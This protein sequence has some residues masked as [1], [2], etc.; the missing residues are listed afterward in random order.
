MSVS[1]PSRGKVSISRPREA[2][3][4]PSIGPCISD[5]LLVTRLR[6]PEQRLAVGTGPLPG[7]PVGRKVHCG[8]GKCVR[9]CPCACTRAHTCVH[10]CMRV[11]TCMRAR[12]SAH[13][14]THVYACACTH[15]CT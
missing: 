2:L 11:H 14:C 4:A 10:V 6:A 13:A 1:L 9:A 7:F 5:L 8:S 12:M 15:V 3:P